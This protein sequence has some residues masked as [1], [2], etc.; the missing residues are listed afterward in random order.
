MGTIGNRMR[1]RALV[2]NQQTRELISARK[3]SHKHSDKDLCQ[4]SNK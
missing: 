2:Q 3:T 4:V 1:P